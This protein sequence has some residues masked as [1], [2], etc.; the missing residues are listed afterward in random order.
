MAQ[1]RN[2]GSNVWQIVVYLGKDD[3]GKRQSHSET[4]Y[5][6]K[7]QARAY[8]NDLEKELKRNKMGPSKL[9][10]F[11]INDLF[12]KWLS[13]I[14]SSIGIRTYESYEYQTRR[15]RP[16]IGHLQ[17][18]SLTNFQLM[19]Q[20]QPLENE[21]LSIRTI[22]DLHVT[23]RTAIKWGSV[24]NLVERDVLNGVKPPK[25]ERKS[26]DV[27]KLNELR[28]FIENAKGYKYYLVLRVLAL[29]GMRIGEVLG[30]TWGNVDFEQNKIKITQSADLKH[31]VSKETK[32]VN[33]LREI[34][35][36]EETMNEFRLQKKKSLGKWSPND[37]VFQGENGKPTKYTAIFKTKKAVLKKAG[38]H[39][40]RL[41]DL[42]H[43]MGSILLDNGIPLTAVS[44]TLGQVP[45]TTAGVYGH[46][47][48]KGKSIANLLA[49][50]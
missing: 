26:R 27:F 10:A 49:V 30:L 8:G 36:D 39:H 12:D 20:L 23:L 17:L 1:L 24:F 44:G 22:K 16:F 32:T 33:S 2:R 35:L 31:R 50:N 9:V 46:S 45:A 14:K 47:L 19:E 37:Y 18:Y 6:T 4:F 34:E 21:K 3:E 28:V 7:S 29:T 43:G 11:T 13:S 25:L 42:R 48:R 5:G 41:H 38:L 15:L 40:I